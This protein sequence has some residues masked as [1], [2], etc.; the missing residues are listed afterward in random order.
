MRGSI[1]P[2]FVRKSVR[3]GPLTE[4]AFEIGLRLASP[5]DHLLHRGLDGREV[6]IRVIRDLPPVEALVVVG[7]RALDD[8]NP[9]VEVDGEAVVG[10]E[11]EVE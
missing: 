8:A 7:H 6:A 5:R 9:F 11:V 1:D 4:D 10:A 3:S 2:A